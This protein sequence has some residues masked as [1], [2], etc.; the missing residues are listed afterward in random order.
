MDNGQIPLVQMNQA[1]SPTQPAG[2]PPVNQP[3]PNPV[4]PSRPMIQQVKVMP[5]P[6]KDVAGLVKTIVIVILSLV[7]LTFIGLF[8]W[9]FGQYNSVSEDVEG[10][11]NVAVAEAK[12]E[13]YKKDQLDFAE[14]EK[15][16]YKTFAGP[17]DYGQLTFE[18]PKT[19]SVYVAAAATTGGDFN[20][21][22]N[23]NQVDAV[24]KDTINALRVTILNKSFESITAE[25][26]RA[27]EQKDANLSME[28]VTV[29][30]APANRYTGK[31]PGT[32]LSG[33]IVIFKI[34]DKT[35]ILQTDSVL[36]KDDFDRL[37]E[38]VTFNA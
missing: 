8:I 20:A 4:D 12:D 21:Y 2:T 16:P 27:M 19:W 10:Q 23:P 14:F 13:Q 1:S 29:N 37:V 25:Y 34:R 6:K 36:F 7:A 32:D 3:M 17:V 24:G 28:T 33:F 31:I 15:N 26:Q 11:I 22:F 30:G 9:M 35:V 5:E 18:Y 38:T